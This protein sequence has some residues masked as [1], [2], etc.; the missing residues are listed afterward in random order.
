QNAAS[1]GDAPPPPKLTGS[2][3]QPP[4]RKPPRPRPESP[5]GPTPEAPA[6]ASSSGPR[7]R[8]SETVAGE[9]ARGI[10]ERLS[11][12]WQR[13]DQKLV[14]I[15]VAIVAVLTFCVIVFYYIYTAMAG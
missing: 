2:D 5:D 8:P 10:R 13:V 7:R 14:A 11:E 12:L 9:G 3:P 1:G 4:S 15:I 6:A